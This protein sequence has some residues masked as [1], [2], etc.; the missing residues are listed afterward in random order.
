MGGFQS[1][2]LARKALEAQLE[3]LLVE[4]ATLHATL[5]AIQ[6]SR[7]W[8]VLHLA[9]R[10]LRKAK[11]IARRRPPLQPSHPMTE[12]TDDQSTVSVVPQL[13]T[14]EPDR[15]GGPRIPSDQIF[16]VAYIVRTGVH[17]AASMRYRGFNLIEALHEVGIEATYFDEPQISDRIRDV[18]GY[19]LIVLV[20]RP[21]S[22]VVLDLVAAADRWRIPVVFDVDDY[23]FE[24]D[25]IPHIAFIQ[26]QPPEVGQ[27][28]ISQYRRMLLA[29]GYFTSA[30]RTLVNRAHAL[31][32]PGFVIRNGFNHSQLILSEQAVSTR[33]QDTRIRLG[34]FSGTRSHQADFRVISPVLLRLL[35]EFP[36]VDL[37]VAGD[38]DLTEFPEFTPFVGRVHS[39][40][41]VPWMDLPA[42]MATAQ[43]NLVPLERNPFTE[44]KSNLKYYEAA[45]VRVPTVATPTGPFA[46][47]IRHGENGLLA[48]TQDEWY[49]ALRLLIENPS[50]R[51]Q[52]GEQ[53]YQ[54]AIQNY[55]PKIVAADA[56]AAYREIIR[57]HRLK[58]GVSSDTITVLLVLSDLDRAIRDHAPALILAV[59]MLNQGS[60]VTLL[61]PDGEWSAT[62]A[63]QLLGDHL[64]A[65]SLTVQVGGDV[66][67]AD[68]LIAGDPAAAYRVAEASHRGRSAV[69]IPSD[70]DWRCMPHGERRESASGSF[71]LGLPIFTADMSAVAQLQ[72]RHP[73]AV[74]QLL[75]YWRSVNHI[76]RTRLAEPT[77]LV[78]LVTI[79]LSPAAQ[80]AI[81]NTIRR[82][83][84]THPQLPIVLTGQ[85]EMLADSID[86]PHRVVAHPDQI[87]PSVP[88]SK[89]R[90]LRLVIGAAMTPQWAINWIVQG[91]SVVVAV[92]DPEFATQSETEIP[93]VLI[94]EQRLLATLET[95]FDNQ[96]QHSAMALQSA[97]L[98]AHI[99]KPDAA[100][101][102]L[103]RTMSAA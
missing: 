17:D 6:H 50:I 37:L 35:S 32:R 4:N 82:I 97:G 21:T 25:V 9:K 16:R 64:R 92:S 54:H 15:T 91:C 33:K 19:D 36:Q 47:S 55:G 84:A 11:R 57:T 94:T 101:R 43:I 39:R 70:Y 69:Y 22:D 96:I 79:E 102:Q 86:I 80:V 81:V 89:G 63:Q 77:E 18:L 12:V 44:C 68:L 3:K 20:R 76:P 46:Q 7:A 73:S 2:S 58:L 14:L 98:V 60:A 42:E 95:M 5:Q 59:E 28:W 52:I 51:R 24:D 75:P 53:A 87:L 26:H 49:Q 34:Y 30:T 83:H 65:S 71:E 1:D 85:Y 66:P 100:A 99:S 74:V 67:C 90:S 23:I 38:F 62:S 88:E 31:G 40:P 61:L 29:A 56:Q 93:K 13:R 27:N 78:V 8:R 72:R 41:F 48:Q 103:L 45:I 10:V